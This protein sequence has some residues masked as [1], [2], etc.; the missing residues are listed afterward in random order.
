MIDCCSE[1]CRYSSFDLGSAAAS[2]GWALFSLNRRAAHRFTAAG[3]QREEMHAPGSHMCFVHVHVEPQRNNHKEVE[4]DP[5]RDL[6][7]SRSSSS[8]QPW[9]R[10][11]STV[12]VPVSLPE[13]NHCKELSFFTVAACI[14]RD[15][16]L[17]MKH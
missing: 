7:V 3:T 5:G 14:L 9:V 15:M 10:R 6:C 16:G 17:N 13:E 11:F 8:S 2:G 1:K 12:S 4:C